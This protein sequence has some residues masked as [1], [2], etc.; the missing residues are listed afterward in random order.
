MVPTWCWLFWIPQL[1]QRI[2]CEDLSQEGFEITE[3][4]LHKLAAMYP[5]A[6]FPILI[7]ELNKLAEEEEQG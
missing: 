1:L 6:L 4:L 5:Q 2:Y 3:A 7:G